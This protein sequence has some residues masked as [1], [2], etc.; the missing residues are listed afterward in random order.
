MAR[1]EAVN[2]LFLS[3]FP[4]SQRDH[5]GVESEGARNAKR[6]LTVPRV[7]VVNVN[8]LPVAGEKEPTLLRLLAMVVRFKKRSVALVP[9]LPE[10]R[11]SLLDP[12][13][14]VLERD[15]VRR[16][17]DGALGVQNRD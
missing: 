5:V 7:R 1:S 6:Q 3:D 4:F 14:E 8:A 15:W 10:L 2:L 13:F 17:E 11:A 16:S 12:A 9:G